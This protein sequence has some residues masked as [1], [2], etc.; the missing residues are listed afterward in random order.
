MLRK[1]SEISTNALKPS[2][3]KSLM[4]NRMP[5]LDT[6]VFT[7]ART[8]RARY[9]CA[10]TVPRSKRDAV[11]TLLAF[12]QE[13]SKIPGAVSEPMLGRIRL[14]WWL[15]ALP[16]M[17]K[18]QAPAHPVAQGLAPFGF[19]TEHLQGLIEAR[20]FDL[21]DAPITFD[22][23]C[24]Y[25]LATGGVFQSLVLEQLGV[26]HVGAE[27]AAKDIGAAGA[28][29]KF[30]RNGE[31]LI[32]GIEAEVIQDQIQKWLQGA[33]EQ[34]IPKSLKKSA[35]PAL[36]LASLIDRRLRLGDAANDGVGAVF[37]VWWGK[38][39]GRY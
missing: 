24:A 14:Q 5:V 4:K 9:L 3:P 30:L 34:N 23:L 6:E 29:V 21:E 20:N 19:K 33:R 39:T 1:V 32:E 25:A 13:I 22:G 2:H 35:A 8:D 27:A 7:L 15:E 38:T 16:A 28:L 36:I 26:V 10:L 12:D 31:S 37:R 11:L 18:G 17:A